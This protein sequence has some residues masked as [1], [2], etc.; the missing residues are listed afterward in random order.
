MEREPAR[1]NLG[2]LFTSI[3]KDV[4]CGSSFSLALADRVHKATMEGINLTAKD[5]VTIATL[6]EST[7]T[8]M[9]DR[10]ELLD[11]D[12]KDIDI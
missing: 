8:D 2:T 11:V 3:C 1:K 12:I 10:D 5:I 9:L 4:G 7:R 6:Y